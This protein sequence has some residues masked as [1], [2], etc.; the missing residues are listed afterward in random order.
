M[1]ICQN[2]I[3][4]F[5]IY[6]FGIISAKAQ[7]Q[8]ENKNSI[9]VSLG[10]LAGVLSDA[11][12]S[13]LNYRQSGSNYTLEYKR[14]GSNKKSILGIQINAGLSTLSTDA[15]IF[16]DT[17]SI[18][19]QLD[20]FYLKRLNQITSKSTLYLGGQITSQVKSLDWENTESFSYFSTHSFGIKGLY[21]HK[22]MERLTFEASMH[23]PLISLLARPPYNGIDEEVIENQDNI[24]A[25][26]TNG[27]IESFNAYFKIETKL[28][29]TYALT[30]SFA[31][32][33]NFLFDYNTIYQGNDWTQ[34]Q[35]QTNA[36]LAYNF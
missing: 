16:F 31:I 12:F 10:Y 27:T 11:N 18:Q 35:M 3:L 34:F 4:L 9:N 32:K 20:V 29:I 24:L 7:N 30:K 1:K 6:L 26:I 13:P 25:L 14:L 5:A 21:Q 15:S 8:E 17:E 23:I 28:N 36:G 22:L 2:V 19:A 33:V